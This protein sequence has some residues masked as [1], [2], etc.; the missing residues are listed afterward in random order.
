MGTLRVTLSTLEALTK[1]C[2]ELRYS[3]KLNECFGSTNFCIWALK[4][5]MITPVGVAI[6]R[7]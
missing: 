4:T 6:V 2:S 1:Q 5:H 7:S 3:S